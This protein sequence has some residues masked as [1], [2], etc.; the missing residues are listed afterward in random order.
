MINSSSQHF[1]ISCRMQINDDPG[2]TSQFVFHFDLKNV[3]KTK[4]KKLNDLT[5]S[6]FRI[7]DIGIENYFNVYELSR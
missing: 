2:K 4:K 5:K 7:V 3:N 6:R 1:E